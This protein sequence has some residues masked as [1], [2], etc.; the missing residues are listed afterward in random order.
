MIRYAVNPDTARCPIGTPFPSI[1]PI[2][3]EEE[4]HKEDLDM[5]NM[6]AMP[7]TKEERG[8][9]KDERRRQSSMHL[10]DTATNFGK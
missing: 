4:G 6:Q 8:K 7:Q 3:E 5:Q 9:T 2:M 10:N 1:V